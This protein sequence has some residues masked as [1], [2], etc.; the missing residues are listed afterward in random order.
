MLKKI[1]TI[2]LLPL[3]GACSSLSSED[4]LSNAVEQVNIKPT[5][6]EVV[7][8]TL[9]PDNIS[10]KN[11]GVVKSSLLITANIAKKEQQ[12]PESQLKMTL[13]YFENYK[14]Y[15]YAVIDGQKIKIKEY[16]V[17]TSVCTEHCTATQY[18]TFPVKNE[19][20][21]AAAETELV[22]ELKPNNGGKVLRFSVPG[23]YLNAI[24]EG[25][26][27]NIIQPAPVVVKAETA[28][29]IAMSKELFIKA[30]AAEKEQ[31]TDWAFKNR[32]TISAELKSESKIVS[33]LE[34]WYQQASESQRAQ[35][36]TWVIA[37]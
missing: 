21:T 15:A 11:H 10:G 9:I 7:G 19:T 28:D 34:Y 29:P 25:Y 30:S 17:A 23:G 1:I 16:A 36:L 13:S 2:M 35:I 22:F 24:T 14:P 4:D 20:L 33:M 5:Y 3:L 27:Q 6:I 8:K 18:F 26:K 37:Q 32:K 31:F 12:A